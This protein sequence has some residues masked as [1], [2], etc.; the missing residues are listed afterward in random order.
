MRRTVCATCRPGVK[1]KRCEGEGRERA[2]PGTAPECARPRAQQRRRGQA[3]G[4]VLRLPWLRTSLRPRT[5]ALQPRRRRWGQSGCPRADR[6]PIFHFFQVREG[7]ILPLVLEGRRIAPGASRGRKV[8]TPKGAMPRNLGAPSQEGGP[9]DT[10]GRQ[11]RE[12][13][14][15]TVPQ[16]TNRPA[17]PEA[18]GKAE[19]QCVWTAGL[20]SQWLVLGSAGWPQ[21]GLGKGE[22]AG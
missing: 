13:C 22:K 3:R 12:A 18:A 2:H 10:R 5:G 4:S 20:G 9:R 19:H 1:Y 7:S 6:G 8:R 17:L 16:K 14:R 11:C 15:R 21:E